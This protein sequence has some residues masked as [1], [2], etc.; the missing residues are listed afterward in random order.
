MEFR[1]TQ[2]CPDHRSAGGRRHG[3]RAVLAVHVDPTAP[4]S[5]LGSLHHGRHALSRRHAVGDLLPVQRPRLH[6]P[7]LVVIGRDRAAQGR[8]GRDGRLLLRTSPQDGNG[9]R[10]PVRAG[11][12]LRIVHGGLDP[13]AS[14]ER[15]PAHTVG[16]ARHRKADSTA[17]HPLGQRAGR[18]RGPAVLRGSP[19]DERLCHLRHPRL[20]HHPHTAQARPRRR[21]RGWTGSFPARGPV[22]SHPTTR[23]RAHSVPGGRHRAGGSRPPSVS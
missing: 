22:H 1:H 15:I 9:G 2:R 6:I 10:I 3:V 20:F 16:L 13:V 17:G 19:R 11:L 18:A 4:H 21:G 5:P 23:R 12:R 14:D 8:G 7:V